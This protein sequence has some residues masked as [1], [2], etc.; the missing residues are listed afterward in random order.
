MARLECFALPHGRASANRRLA[1]CGPTTILIFEKEVFI[2][3]AKNRR[4][5]LKSNAHMALRAP[6][7]GGAPLAHPAHMKRI[8]EKG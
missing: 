1:A 2:K 7:V 8:K 3:R 5:R 6:L 4:T